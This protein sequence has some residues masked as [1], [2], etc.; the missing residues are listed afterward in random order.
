[1]QTL[2][3]KE[4]TNELFKDGKGIKITFVIFLLIVIT[5]VIGF[6][7]YFW[8]PKQTI[9]NGLEQQVLLIKMQNDLETGKVSTLDNLENEYNDLREK[10]SVVTTKYYPEL[11]Q[12]KITVELYNM[13]N[14]ADLEINSTTFTPAKFE[15][16][17]FAY[18]K[19]PEEENY[20][21]S[22]VNDFNKYKESQMNM[23]KDLIDN[24]G[25]E[26]ENKIEK[27]DEES[28]SGILIETMDINFTFSGSYL[29]FTDF[30]REVNSLNR[31]IIIRNVTLNKSGESIE[32]VSGRIELNY[33]A[34]PKL[35]ID[36][37]ERDKNFEMWEYNYPS[38]KNNP[39]KE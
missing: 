19:L 38:G 12:K 39:F 10:V 32:D 24:L 17:E 4:R 14:E 2:N 37:T 21:D 34:I 16:I 7:K 31:A 35:E 20:L 30:L 5:I 27:E 9:I 23:A 13:A 11:I 3:I 8:V 22:L 29:D 6:Y 25:E 15:Q 36:K 28:E 26:N 18:E 33:F 1:M